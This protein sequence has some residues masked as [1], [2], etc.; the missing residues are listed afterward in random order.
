MIDLI[1]VVDDPASWHQEN[2]Q[3]NSDHYSALRYLGPQAV[4]LIQEHMASGVYYNP[5]VKVDGE[6]R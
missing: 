4:A 1:F 5:F 6:V 2:M 3:M